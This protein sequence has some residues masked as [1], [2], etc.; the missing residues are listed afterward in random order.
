M[1]SHLL[2]FIG[3]RCVTIMVARVRRNFCQYRWAPNLGPLYGRKGWKELSV[4]IGGLRSQGL[5]GTSVSI[6]CGRECA[7]GLGF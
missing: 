2:V 4:G 7:G 3:L 6:G 5:K 1:I